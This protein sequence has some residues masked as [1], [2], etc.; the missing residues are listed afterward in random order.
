MRNAVLSALEALPTQALDM[1]RRGRTLYGAWA[2]KAAAVVSS[3]TGSSSINGAQARAGQLVPKAG[4]LQRH[5]DVIFAVLVATL[6]A[7]LLPHALRAC[8]RQRHT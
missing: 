1:W 6:A 4:T 2:A 5:G 7:A 8:Q 3:A